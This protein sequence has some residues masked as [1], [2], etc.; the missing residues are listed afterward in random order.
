MPIIKT[1]NTKFDLMCFF[2]SSGKIKTPKK[3]K[4][5]DKW[6]WR[7]FQRKDLAIKHN[8]PH[9]MQLQIAQW[10]CFSC[11]FVTKW[12][13]KRRPRNYN[14]W[15]VFKNK[16]GAD[17]ILEDMSIPLKQAKPSQ[18]YDSG[19]RKHSLKKRTAFPVWPLT[20]YMRGILHLHTTPVWLQKRSSLIQSSRARQRGERTILQ[21]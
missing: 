2:W 12:Q 16:K 17:W 15:L 18:L 3:F 14:R 5:N 4:N 19:D 13:P 1:K 7:N 9:A 10:R 11:I 6:K 20:R 21:E 8:L